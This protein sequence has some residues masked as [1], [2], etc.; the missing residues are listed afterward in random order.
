MAVSG[1]T[2]GTTGEIQSNGPLFAQIEFYIV[3]S[4]SLGEELAQKVGIV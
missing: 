2:E 1:V 4:K 3:Q